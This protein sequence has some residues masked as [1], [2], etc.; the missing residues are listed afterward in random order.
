MNSF[1]SH[2]C[3]ERIWIPHFTTVFQDRREGIK[4]KYSKSNTVKVSCLM[5]SETK[6]WSNNSNCI[7]ID[8]YNLTFSCEFITTRRFLSTVTFS[9]STDDNG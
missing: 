5:F 7:Y 3:N 6:S 1:K 8:M 9:L 2:S 4:E